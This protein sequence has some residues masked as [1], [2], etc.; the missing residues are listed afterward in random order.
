MGDRTSHPPGTF[1]WA[2]LVTTDADSAKAFYTA[3]LGWDY[4]DQP[5]GDDAVYSMAARDGKQVAALYTDAGQPPHWN[6]YVTVVSVDETTAKAKAAGG[7]EVHEPVDVMDVGRM[8]FIADPAGAT[9]FLWEPR[10]HIGA[11]LV[12]APGA[13]NWNDLITPDP[14]GAARFYG[15]VFGW[16]FEEVPDTDG[17]RVIKNGDRE[18]G[19]VF[20]REDAAPGWIPYFGHEDVARAIADIPGR[21]GDVL[22]G[23]VKMWDGAIGVFS[24]PQGAPFALWTGHY[25]D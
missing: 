2:E 7:S 1:S 13:M 22:E 4:D 21:G 3:L 15:D 19:G 5:V 16:V 12:N 23:P 20:P 8:A 17:Y 9:I 24:D 25:D 14:D 11:E 6:S 10:R 18:N